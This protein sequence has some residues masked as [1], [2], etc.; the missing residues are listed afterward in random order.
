[1]TVWQACSKCDQIKLYTNFGATYYASQISYQGING[2]YYNMLGLKRDVF[3]DL[4]GT[5][6]NMYFDS[7]TRTSG[8]L[9]YG[10]PH[11]LQDPAC[12]NSSTPDLWDNGAVC[13][14]TVTVRQVMFTNIQKMS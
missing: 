6:T 11:L 8:A 12:L 9:T 13:D 5:L 7:N 2:A 14:Q 3:Y 4:D 1:M 10:W